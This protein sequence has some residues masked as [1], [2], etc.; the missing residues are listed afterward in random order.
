MKWNSFRNF[1]DFRNWVEKQK[2]HFFSFKVGVFNL[3]RENFD[4]LGHLFHTFFPDAPQSKTVGSILTPV[5][6]L[7]YRGLDL[8]STAIFAPPGS[9]IRQGDI[10]PFG[11]AELCAPLVKPS[12]WIVL[13]HSCDLDHK[14][15]A[16]ILPGYTLSL[17]GSSTE[18][19]GF[20]EKVMGNA[21]ENKNIRFFSLPPN[22]SWGDE[23]LVFDLSQIYS[24]PSNRLKAEDVIQ[25]LTYVGNA[26]FQNRVAIA[27]FRD[28][29]D[30]DDDRVL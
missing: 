8:D 22:D 30:S 10:I 15:F 2:K 29:K 1:G 25:S 13:T 21:S 23:R 17:L 14:P 26:Y 9:S 27:L 4:G 5:G 18:Q 16:Q 6:W 20:S 24:V 12:H 11:E 3:N 28:V 7:H 19:L